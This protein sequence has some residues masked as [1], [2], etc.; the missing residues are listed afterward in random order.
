LTI[1]RELKNKDEATGYFMMRS[2]NELKRMDWFPDEGILIRVG[3][4]DDLDF[5]EK[6]LIKAEVIERAAVQTNP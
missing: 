6:G 3:R 1:L 4:R 2:G 5:F